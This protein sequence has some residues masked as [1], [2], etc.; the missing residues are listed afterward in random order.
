MKFLTDRTRAVTKLMVNKSSNNNSRQIEK[1]EPPKSLTMTLADFD[2]EELSAKCERKRST[3]KQLLLF[4]AESLFPPK[5]IHSFASLG[6][7]R[8][9][10]YSSSKQPIMTM[11]MLYC[12]VFLGRWCSFLV[13]I[14]RCI[15]CELRADSGEYS[16]LK[17]LDK[18]IE[19]A[20][21]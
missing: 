12:N 19:V 5:Y 11:M 3:Q 9:W 1:R 14:L 6:L 16:L 7:A 8:R 17:C 18:R 4:S 2:I 20:G 10:R 15:F 13:L 21:D